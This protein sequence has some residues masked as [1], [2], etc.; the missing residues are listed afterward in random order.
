MLRIDGLGITVLGARTVGWDEIRVV[1]LV[2]RS[3]TTAV[4]PIP[5]EGMNLPLL[6]LTLFR[7][8]SVE[9]AARNTKRWGG[10]LVLLPKALDADETRIAAAISHFGRGTPVVDEPARLPGLP[11]SP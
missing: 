2:R 10:P 9:R 6:D 11:P 3:M 5:R 4:V 7:S 1:H 8:R